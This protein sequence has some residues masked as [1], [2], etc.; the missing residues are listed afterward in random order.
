[1]TT[2]EIDKIQY[3]A[4]K[5]AAKARKIKLSAEQDL[6]KKVDPYF[7]NAF[8]FIEYHT[9]RDGKVDVTLDI[10]VKYHRFDEL[11]YG[12]IHP[13][14]P[15]RFTDKIRANSGALCHA[16]FPRLH[17][18]FDFDEENIPQLCEDILDFLEKYC[19]DFL[20]MVEKEYGDLD[21]YYIARKE[22]NPRLAG[23][24]C[25]DKGDYEG[26]A[27]CFSHPA[28][29]GA[30]SIWSV[31]IYTDEQR[32]RA[33]VNG[34]NIFNDTFNRSRQEQFYDYAIALQNGLDWTNDRAMY[35]LLPEERKASRN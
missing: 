3:Q 5:I 8:Y 28:M 15:L 23:L 4:M 31:T 11:Q 18:A 2:K 21:N 6:Y 34:K 20:E 33:E 22:I 7:F 13:D 27:E 30:T 14:S 17:Q 12:I 19:R 24:A 25:L 26:A 35:G 29:D 32:H 9:I 10:T 16:A 1:M